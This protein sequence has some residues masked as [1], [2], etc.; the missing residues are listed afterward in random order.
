VAAEAK[1]RSS[2]TKH[3]NQP[4]MEWGSAKVARGKQLA[5]EAKRRSSCAIRKNQPM[6]ERGRERV[7]N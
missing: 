1:R 6:M 5:M 3:N 7:R 4:A 2:G